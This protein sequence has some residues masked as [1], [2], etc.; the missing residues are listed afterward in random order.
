M[1]EIPTTPGLPIRRRGVAA[2][3]RR[4]EQ[5]LV[6]RR[7]AGVLAPGK[8]C[9]P[10]GG[11]EPG[12]SEPQALCREMQ[13]ELSVD[14]RPGQCVWRSTT[15]WGISL[16]WWTGEI[17]HSAA[18]RPNPAEVES[19]HWL[20]S[21]EMLALAELLESNRLFLDALAARHFSLH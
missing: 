8:Y 4:D 11:V 12:E 2:V 18:L 1:S 3:V 15:P 21:G 9:F 16:A 5:F 14:I 7:A 19:F 10:G 17:D 13:E 20:S 6:I